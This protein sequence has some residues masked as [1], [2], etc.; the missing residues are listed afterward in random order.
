[1]RPED[2]QRT[3][4]DRRARKTPLYWPER[5]TGFDRRLH[6]SALGRFVHDTLHHLSRSDRLLL[7]LLVAVNAANLVD[8]RVTFVLLGQGAIEVN[9]LMRALLEW[10]PVFA[11]ITKALIV[12]GVTLGVWAGRRF[13]GILAAGVAAGLAFL[14][15]LI[16]EI[17]LLAAFR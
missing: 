12:F 11:A 10:N 16:Y 4:R 3:A 5:R 6:P 8:M 17:Q 13:K 1:M 15:L 7:A 14:L 9:P 2:G